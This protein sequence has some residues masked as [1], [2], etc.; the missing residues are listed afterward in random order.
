[1][2]STN[3]YLSKFNAYNMNAHTHMH[4]HTQTHRGTHVRTH[5]HTSRSMQKCEVQLSHNL[6]CWNILF[7]SPLNNMLLYNNTDGFECLCTPVCNHSNYPNNDLITSINCLKLDSA[8]IPT[9]TT[10]LIHSP[11][12]SRNF[13]KM[14]DSHVGV[15][16]NAATIQFFCKA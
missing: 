8:E 9:D 2:F 13:N 1:M 11:Y 7:K 5:T 6:T 3:T 4:A 16:L 15:K 12:C 10:W 14:P